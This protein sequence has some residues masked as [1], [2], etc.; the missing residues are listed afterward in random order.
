M[1][2][3]NTTSDIMIWQFTAFPLKSNLPQAKC[4]L[5]LNI[6]NFVHK[7]PHELPNGLRLRILAN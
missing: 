4:N 6:I 7:L 2:N 3:F 5:I 1:E